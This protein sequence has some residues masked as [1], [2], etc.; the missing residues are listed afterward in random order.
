MSES[1]TSQTQH[2]DAFDPLKVWTSSMETWTRIA[3]DNIG[4][5][6]SF[7]HRSDDDRR[8][9]MAFWNTGMDAWTQLA[10]DGIERLQ[11]FYSQ[12]AEIESVAYE[13]ARKSARDLGDMMS[14][15][16]TYAAD[17][18][19]EWQ[20]LGIETVRRG[21]HAMRSRQGAARDNE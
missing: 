9:P 7:Y 14:E 20:Q 16:V 3:R 18:T 12:V 1:K 10:C 2:D 6:Q 11:S 5:M 15:S 21:A 19:R 17:L 4:R 8:D 13:R